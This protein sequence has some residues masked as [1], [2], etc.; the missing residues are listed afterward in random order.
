LKALGG[1]SIPRHFWHTN[2]KRRE[3]RE[4]YI[5]WKIKFGEEKGDP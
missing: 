2:K 3:G 5:T 4:R 1:S